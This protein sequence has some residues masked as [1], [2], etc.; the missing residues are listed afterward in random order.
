MASEK[1]KP[2]RVLRIGDVS[3]SI[4]RQSAGENREFHTISLQRSYVKDGKRDYSS[5]LTLAELPAAIEVLRMAMAYIATEQGEAVTY[6][7][8]ES[9]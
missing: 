7:G 9:E 4:F 3:C 5:S 6:D 8:S 2:E 1:K